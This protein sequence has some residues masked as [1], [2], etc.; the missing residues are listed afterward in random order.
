MTGPA[1]A[2][3][4]RLPPVSAQE[5]PRER[6][7]EPGGLP[8]E[9]ANPTPTRGVCRHAGSTVQPRERTHLRPMAPPR[10]EATV[11]VTPPGG[12]PPGGAR[13][14]EAASGGAADAAIAELAAE[15]GPSLEGP[16]WWDAMIAVGRGRLA[17]PIAAAA[18]L[19]SAGAAARAIRRG[20]DRH[21]GSPRPI[22]APGLHELRRSR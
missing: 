12:P 14:G 22:P 1:A 7:L 16:G 11:P 17:L 19:A 21:R 5:H 2:P 9:H 10:A 8:E 18:A 4:G 20:R 3:R 6:H 13:P 15:G